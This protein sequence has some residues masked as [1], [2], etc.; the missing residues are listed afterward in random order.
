MRQHTAET[1]EI[2][3]G[4]VVTPT[5]VVNGHITIVGD[6][7]AAVTEAAVASDRWLVPGFVDIHNHG[8]GGHS[9][10]SGDADAARQAAA[11]HL[12][13]GT[14]TVLASLVSAPLALMRTA[15]AA[16]AP[17]VDEGVIAG[18]HFE[19]P[20]LS[21]ARCGAQNP[22][23]LRDPCPHE[24][25]ELLALG[26]DTIRM[27]TI[28]PERDG[29][30]AAIELLAAHGAVPAVGHTDATFD[31]VQ[32]AV[33]AG[34]R[35]A[36]HLFNGMRPIHHREP[37]P[38]VALLAATPVTC[39]LIADGVHL[40]DGTLTFAARTAGADRAALITDAI[41]ATGMADG[42]Y[43]LGGQAV[44]V[45]DGVARLDTDDGTPGAIAGS[46]LTMDAALRRA[47]A[48]GIPLVDVVKM[49]AT[50]PAR[51]IG[52]AH[53]RGALAVGQ[54]A[55]LVELDDQLRVRRVMRAGQWVANNTAAT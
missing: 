55:D 18:I 24:L 2:I 27:M 25:H 3:H 23:Y 45:T 11:F 30:L 29:A 5:G 49:A 17:L 9:F 8:G 46:T 39:E 37:G 54:R 7:I 38:V 31:Q 40:H 42:G 28:A 50:T 1:G 36:T 41:D 6:R 19:G 10:T 15:T 43:D 34:A 47:V 48:A 51:T 4:R 13:H 52:L 32:A 26:G 12:R 14:T 33:H 20:Y 16:F 44:R 53:D 21:Q 35:V 22:A